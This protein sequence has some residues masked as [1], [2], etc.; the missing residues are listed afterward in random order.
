MAKVTGSSATAHLK[1]YAVTTGEQTKFA[2]GKKLPFHLEV[3]VQKSK[4]HNTSAL[5]RG[6]NLE[7]GNPEEAR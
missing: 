3:Y 4:A 6:Q 2:I 5:L 1:E 7:K